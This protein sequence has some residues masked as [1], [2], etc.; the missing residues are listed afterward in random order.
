[1]GKGTAVENTDEMDMTSYVNR[2]H[3]AKEIDVVLEEAFE[4]SVRTKQPNRCG[5]RTCKHAVD[6]VD[7]FPDGNGKFQILFALME[8]LVNE[9]L[10]S[11][12]DK[13]VA[14]KISKNQIINVM[15]KW[16][17]NWRKLLS[18]NPKKEFAGHVANGLNTLID[19]LVNR[20]K[21]N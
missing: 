17:S 9:T 6:C 3:A 11:N 8:K 2:L 16:N 20:W 21:T 4:R 10:H 19:Y 12:L 7:S 1:M 13:N 14:A 18:S 15:E 5:W